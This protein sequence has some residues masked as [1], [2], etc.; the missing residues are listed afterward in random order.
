MGR[1]GSWIWASTSPMVPKHQA[2]HRAGVN[3]CS[4]EATWGPCC[5]PSS[6]PSSAQGWRHGLKMMNP[7]VCSGATACLGHPC[8][9]GQPPRAKVL[10]L[11]SFLVGQ[12]LQQLHAAKSAQFLLLCI[13]HS[14]LGRVFTPS[15][16][17]NSV[18][19]GEAEG[20]NRQR[21]TLS[22]PVSW[23]ALALSAA[24]VG[25]V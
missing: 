22:E 3:T 21:A 2:Q 19:I 12:D 8:P 7:P 11:G 25:E 9:V 24:Q 5:A 23:P 6:S 13:V 18:G 14:P 20:E 15:P 10:L 4:L 17:G 1:P 16:E